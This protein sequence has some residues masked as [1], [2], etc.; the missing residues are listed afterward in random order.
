LREDIGAAERGGV[1]IVAFDF[2]R[3]SEMALYQQRVGVAAESH[4]RRVVHG[5]A[6]DYV[7]GL[8]NVGDDGLERELDASG[9]AGEAERGAHDFE[10]SAARNGVEPFGGA[11][12]EF[13]VQGFLEGGTAGEFFETPPIFR[14]RFFRSV[15]GG[16]GVDSLADG[17]HVELL[18]GA[19]VFEFD[20]LRFV[21]DR[22]CLLCR[23]YGTRR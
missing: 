7:F 4:R 1:L 3:A 11:F 8:A 10:E 18:A 22:H 19:D 23:P 17:A 5:A 9:H 2:C 20:E 16:G 6:G 13:S 12:G 15:V 14:T 21:V